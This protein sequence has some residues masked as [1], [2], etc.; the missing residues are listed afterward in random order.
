MP[1]RTLALL[2]FSL[3][4]VTLAGCERHTPKQVSARYWAAVLE[5][6]SQAAAEYVT[7]STTPGLSTFI[8][9]GPG[10][11][12]SFG[13]TERSEQRARVE[14]FIHW[15]DEDEST[16]FET[17]TV[18]VRENNLWKVDPAATRAEFFESVYRSA[19]TGLE[20][21]LDDSLRAFREFGSELSQEMARELSE[22]TRELQE[23]SKKANEEIQMF[24]ES[25]DEELRKELE[26]RR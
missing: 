5:G 13:D 15:V 16:V 6:D 26:R 10:S 9:P 24:L 21:I 2:F 25:L 3:L 1:A 19:L 4:A 8:E 22:A 17:T 7:D 23:Q 12:V 20:A 18:L 14:T 11:S